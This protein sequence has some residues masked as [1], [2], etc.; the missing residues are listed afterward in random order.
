MGSEMCIRDSGNRPAFATG[1]F[2]GA[3]EFSSNEWIST[4]AF[5]DTMEVGEGNPRTISI[6]FK[7]YL[8]SH[9]GSAPN[10][11][12]WD[13]GLYW[14][15]TTDSRFGTARDGWGLRGFSGGSVGGNNN[16][17][18]FMSQHNGWD[19]QVP[20][21]EGIM[22]RWV[23]IAHIYTGTDLQVYVDGIKR[24]E[25]AQS[26][27]TSGK[28]IWNGSYLRFGMFHT[29]TNVRRTFKGLIDDFRVYKKAFTSTE[30]QALFGNGNGDGINSP[31]PLHFTI[32]G[33]ESPDNFTAVGLPSGLSLNARTGKITGIT[34]DVGEHNVTIKAGNF[35]G[36]SPQ[37]ILKINVKPVSYTHLTL[38]TTPYV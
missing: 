13:P 27:Y 3:V 4:D 24:Y 12:S 38:P 34:T 18:R 19:P 1:Q 29:W 36:F 26:M 11:H 35:L 33:S 37:Q 10:H 22:D 23:H 31:A 2:G 20:V 21:G 15:G 32:T 25:A 8:Q 28:S 7:P 30:V 14:M 9:W 16:Y 6:W 5:A 17:T